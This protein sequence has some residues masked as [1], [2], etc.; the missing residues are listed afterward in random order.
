MLLN[1]YRGFHNLLRS[2]NYTLTHLDCSKP[3]SNG[4]LPNHL[5]RCSMDPFSGDPQDCQRPVTLHC[6]KR[7]VPSA[8]CILLHLEMN[9]YLV[10]VTLHAI[11]YDFICMIRCYCTA[12][13]NHNN[14][15][16]GLVNTVALRWRCTDLASLCQVSL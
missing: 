3:M 14:S 5:L 4:A 15:M 16:G 1:I 9:A 12:C 6:C 8:S 11:S 10:P 7:T 2:Y 13:L